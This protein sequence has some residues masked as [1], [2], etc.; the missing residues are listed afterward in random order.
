LSQNQTTQSR[1]DPVNFYFW[2]NHLPVIAIL[3]PIAK[4]ESIP[5]TL[6]YEMPKSPR[7]SNLQKGL[8]A[9]EA[10]AH[11][12]AIALLKP[13][14]ERGNPEAQCLMGNIAILNH[15]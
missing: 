1:S 2:H 10:K 13:L 12:Q 14:A 4:M 15:L 11:A 8:A 5:T 7:N 3:P 9:F 6:E